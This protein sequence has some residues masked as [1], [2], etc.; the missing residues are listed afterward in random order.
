MAT[1]T[2]TRFTAH[3]ND[4]GELESFEAPARIDT[5]DNFTDPGG[6]TVTVLTW[7][8][9]KVRA[10]DLPPGF[11]ADMEAVHQQIVTKLDAQFPMP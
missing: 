3:F 6:D 10:A 1:R 7:V 4:S 9:Y 5:A 11:V 2:V 8:S